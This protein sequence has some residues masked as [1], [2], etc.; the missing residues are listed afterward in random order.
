M[1]PLSPMQQGML[2]HYLT[3]HQHGA[4]VIQYVCELREDVDADRLA[5]AW[6]RVAARHQPFR[7][8]FHWNEAESPAQEILPHVRLE[9][10]VLD[11]QQTTDEAREQKL[12]ELLEADRNRGFDFGAAPAVRLTLIRWT[13]G[14]SRCVW[15]FP[16]ILMDGRSTI[17]VFSEV[18]E[19]YDRGPDHEL[20]APPQYSTFLE[21]L[22]KRNREG[23]E[24]YWRDLLKGLSGPT[25]LP[26]SAEGAS[27]G[28]KGI[29]RRVL[30]LSTEDTA[31]AA[32]FVESL[33]VTLSTLVSGAW[34]LLLARYAGTDDVVFGAARAG[35]NATVTDADSIVGLFINTLPVRFRC[36]PDA[37]VRSCLREVRRQQV[38]VR[39]YEHTPLT[40]IQRWSGFGAG[41]PLFESAIV[42][43]YVP[44]DGLVHA[45]RPAWTHRTFSLYEPAAIPLTLYARGGD[46]LE[47]RLVYERDRVADERAQR[48]LEHLATLVQGL[49]GNPD[50]LLKDVSIL[51]E[52]ERRQQLF[53]WNATDRPVELN[54]CAHVLIEE[55]VRRTPDAIALVDGINT[56]T[57]QKLD[58]RANRLAHRLLA[59][60]V[61]ADSRVGVC[62]ERSVNLV[63]AVLGVL[64]AGGAYVPLDPDY[65]AERLEYMARDAGLVALVTA[66]DVGSSLAP[67]GVPVVDL[68]AD[69]ESLADESSQRPA[70]NVTAE[71][72]AY[73]IYTSGSTGRPK[74]VMIEHRNVVNFFAAMED[75]VPHSDGGTWLAVTSLAFDISVLELLWPLTR[76]FKVVVTSPLPTGGARTTT[77]RGLEFSLFYFASAADAQEDDK[78]RL[79]LEGARF[80]D[81]RG[82]HAV[83]TPERHFHAFGGL[84]PNPSVTAAAL[85]AITTR[86]RLR[87]GS[88]VLPLHHPVRIAE[89][90]ALV[91]NLSGGR[92][93]ISFAS[94]WQPND[95]ALAPQNYADRKRLMMEGI[96]IVRRLWRGESVSFP[97]PDGKM[98]E[99]RTLPRPHQRELPIWITTAG[100][101]DTYRT[102]GEAGANV[103]THLLGQTVEDVA[104]MI[105]V[106][107][108]ARKKAGHAGPGRV[109][110]M[111]HTFVGVDDSAVRETVRKPMKEYLRSS[112]SLIKG[113]TGAWTARRA[114]SETQTR[115]AGDEFDA[116]SP[117]D[118]ESLLDF[119]FERYFETSGL[120][121][122][123]ERCLDLAQRLREAGVDEIAC[124]IDFGVPT[125][126]VLAHL[127]DLDG[128]RQKTIRQ[129]RPTAW[130]ALSA[131]IRDHG[132]THLQCTPSLARML[133]ADR[134]TRAA[135]G[136]L[137]VLLIGGEPFPGHLAAELREN[138]RGTLLNMYGP[139][140]TT[141]W[142]SMHEVDGEGGTVP[143][144]RPI[145][146]TR[147]YVLDRHAQPVPVGIAGELYIGGAGVVRGYLGRP[148]LT[149][150]RFVAD[151]FRGGRERLYRT[152]DVVRW[153]A[154]GVME[155]L[156]R[157][158][159]QVKIRG[160][161][162]EL[163]EVEAVLAA[164]PDVREVVVHPLQSAEGD[165]ELVA[166]VVGKPGRQPS[167]AALRSHAELQ[168][169]SV[170]VPSHVVILAELP[171]TPNGKV[172]RKA[173][174]APARQ[175]VAMRP[176]AKGPRTRTEELVLGVFREVVGRTDA[177][178]F[179]NFFDLGGHSLMAV[180]LM[181]R[182]RTVTGVDLPLRNLFERPTAAG[183]AEAIDAL[184]WSEWEAPTE[185]TADREEIVL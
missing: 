37:S 121:G 16:H 178:V 142:S 12:R 143:I 128:V 78:Y 73:V 87:A 97:G 43:D 92:V 55:Q 96:E 127:V 23:E 166:Y 31:L 32:S 30:H 67:H 182:L 58:A 38:D 11:W 56:L 91:D 57:Y 185:Q 120:F 116:L 50:R 132:V 64:K 147:L 145:A 79:L 135:L 115:L 7:T 34:G 35:R 174:P 68:T 184:S 177:G 75:R 119:A 183:L 53:E 60:G 74:G 164:H 52:E 158:D 129:A 86:V 180:R 27:D 4:D 83:W 179:D 41:Q 59:L 21:W 167:E 22:G 165:G 9:L 24:R 181:S 46:Q 99:V 133:L 155:F 76:G 13:N 117:E 80:A 144:G 139:T 44:T 54:R 62:M 49:V 154:D 138:I 157:V 141:V 140:E 69:A 112:V 159:H 124:L 94:G 29:A 82:F 28:E 85:A 2:Y 3:D 134:D 146:N 163:G 106:Y 89:E 100:S 137:Q 156:G 65:P 122:T 39:P 161:R 6:N 104:A 40:D 103:L 111:L 26:G 109:T 114:G 162:I 98:V 108:D 25:A 36:T 160:H 125:D 18:F 176:M 5:A 20:P 126:E 10:E 33:G 19:L 101:A 88:V 168:L 84:Y 102:A 71:N 61:Q 113:F 169:P 8:R 15:S 175:D 70:G 17:L 173:L 48:V 63:V 77:R 45:E 90:W 42:F 51:S 110:L 93:D 150:E 123:P 95:F 47:L 131:L 107:R 130:P 66:D 172:D 72:L 151:P 152:G 118:M 153:R 81:R 1:Y 148:D 136:V 14:E 171:L 149:A 170:M 105:S